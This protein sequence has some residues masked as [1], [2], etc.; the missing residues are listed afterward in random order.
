MTSSL[1]SESKKYESS[2]AQMY[3]LKILT[4]PFNIELHMLK[5]NN[6]RQFYFLNASNWVTR[7]SSRPDV[8]TTTVA[9]WFILN[10]C[11][12]DAEM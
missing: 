8:S 5:Y 7:D 6:N 11:I 1:T 3:N 9:H 4:S 10:M 12:S 2:S